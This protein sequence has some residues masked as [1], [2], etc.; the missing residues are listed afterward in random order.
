MTC[1]KSTVSQEELGHPNSVSYKGSSVVSGPGLLSSRS[2]HQTPLTGLP[3]PGHSD[4]DT[5]EV[6][7]NLGRK[8]FFPLRMPAE[9]GC[10]P[11][12]SLLGCHVASWNEAGT[13]EHGAAHR[14]E[15]TESSR[16]CLSPDPTISEAGICDLLSGMSQEFPFLAQ[17]SLDWM[18][19]TGNQ[20]H[21]I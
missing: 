18:G 21:F 17:T 10:T 13:E 1:P 19:A 6:D 9:R 4:R 20:R 3:N 2:F 11:A 8:I 5:N 15:A 12:A 7:E 14:K 16:Y